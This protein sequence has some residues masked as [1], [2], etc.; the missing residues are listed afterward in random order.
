MLFVLYYVWY[1]FVL[2]FLYLELFL[3]VVVIVAFLQWNYTCI[4]PNCTYFMKLLLSMSLI[5]M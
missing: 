3:N 1:K 2:L 4:F 5:S